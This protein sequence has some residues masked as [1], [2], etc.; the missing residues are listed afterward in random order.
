MERR[1]LIAA[2][3]IVVIIIIVISLL[4][5]AYF[6]DVKKLTARWNRRIRGRF[7]DAEMG[8]LK[9]QNLESSR[10]EIEVE[11]GQLNW[12]SGTY[13]V[14]HPGGWTRYAKE[15][16]TTRDIFEAYDDDL[17]S[18]K[19]VVSPDE[20]T[21]NPVGPMVHKFVV[22]VPARETQTYI[23]AELKRDI[24]FSYNLGSKFIFWVTRFN[25]QPKK[26]FDS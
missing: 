9:Y 13:W 18:L 14:K 1:F 7:P 5:Y 20:L 4:L 10:Q 3:V 23:I 21:V 26:N 17:L 11:C 6:C 25:R 19:I 8:I 16:P 12:K 24:S 2:I 22:K 15:I